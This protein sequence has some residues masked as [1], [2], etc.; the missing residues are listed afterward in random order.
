MDVDELQ[1]QFQMQNVGEDLS[2]VQF[3]AELWNLRPRMKNSG[4]AM[5]VPIWPEAYAH[6]KENQQ[7]RLSSS[8]PLPDQCHR[9]PP[10]R[11]MLLGVTSP[12]IAPRIGAARDVEEKCGNGVKGLNRASSAGTLQPCTR[13]TSRF[14]MHGSGRRSSHHFPGV[15]WFPL[16]CGIMCAHQPMIGHN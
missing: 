6:I 5:R 12:A 4:E 8:R 9:S 10:I 11:S 1:Q 16:T 14:L 7:V 15:L 3:N 13:L 2:H